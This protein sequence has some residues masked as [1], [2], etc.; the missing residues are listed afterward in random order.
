MESRDTR[1]RYPAITEL[2]EPGDW[3]L[4]VSGSKLSIPDKGTENKLAKAI[5]WHVGLSL[6]VVYKGIKKGEREGEGR[7]RG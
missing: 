1:V 2:M 6:H 4:G 7:K 3:Q 5:A